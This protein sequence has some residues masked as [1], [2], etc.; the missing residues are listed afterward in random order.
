VLTQ[1]LLGWHTGYVPESWASGVMGKLGQVG[2]KPQF[3][4]PFE[5]FG[6]PVWYPKIV[7][8]A[9][10]ECSSAADAL[11]TDRA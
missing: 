3:F 6:S 4:G 2:L 8:A 11:R 10:A 9:I 5:E 7:S 1:K